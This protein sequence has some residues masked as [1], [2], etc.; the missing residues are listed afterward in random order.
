MTPR[1]SSWSM[2]SNIPSTD[3][4]IKSSD[5][6]IK[7]HQQEDGAEGLWR[8]HNGLYDLRKWIHKHPGGPQW[9]EITKVSI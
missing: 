3:T 1:I 4:S 8:V 7:A 6:W 2:W 9:L 5:N